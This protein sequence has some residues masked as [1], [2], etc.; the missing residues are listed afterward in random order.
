LFAPAATATCRKRAYMVRMWACVNTVGLVRVWYCQCIWERRSWVR[1]IIIIIIIIISVIDFRPLE[2]FAKG[3]TTRRHSRIILQEPTPYRRCEISFPLYGRWFWS[4]LSFFLF[5]S[6]L[7]F[8]SFFRSSF[9]DFLRSRPRPKCSRVCQHSSDD[10][11]ATG[12]NWA[13]W[14][15]KEW[16]LS[17]W[18]EPPK[19]QSEP[20]S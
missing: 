19:S 7:R 16:L 9:R 6:L 5:D 2:V 13:W 17:S 8:S 20:F 18:F 15:L 12:V 11:F 3:K 4:L 14:N 10:K 1:M